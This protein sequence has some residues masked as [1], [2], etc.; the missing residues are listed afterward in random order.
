MQLKVQP[1]GKTARLK[2]LSLPPGQNQDAQQL[3]GSGS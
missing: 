3:V 2:P 1:N